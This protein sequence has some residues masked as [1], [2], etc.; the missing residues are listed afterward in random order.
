MMRLS[1]ASA[2]IPHSSIQTLSSGSSSAPREPG[3]GGITATLPAA[4]VGPFVLD[5]DEIFPGGTIP[6]GLPHA[7]LV[8]FGGVPPG[9]VTMNLTWPDALDCWGPTSFEALADTYTTVLWA[10]VVVE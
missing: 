10:C 6:D 2:S 4:T 3:A 8:G 9:P 5:E 7:P 1:S